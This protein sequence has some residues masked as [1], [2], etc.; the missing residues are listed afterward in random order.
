MHPDFRVSSITPEQRET[1]RKE[2]IRLGG[3][4]VRLIPTDSQRC[5]VGDRDSGTHITCAFF[6]GT[7]CTGSL[8]HCPTPEVWLT[9]S[10][11]VRHLKNQ[12]TNPQCT[13]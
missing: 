10:D 6:I 5:N 4:T 3:I 2:P 13:T 11:F 9:E 8:T 12:L 1:A 7:A